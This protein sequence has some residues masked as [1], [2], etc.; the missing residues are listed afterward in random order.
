M[1]REAALPDQNPA[2][3]ND[4]LLFDAE[5]TPHR[6]LSPEGFL[7]LMA[8]VA[9]I[10][11][12][13]GLVFFLMG[14]WPVIGFLGAD[15]ALIY[16]AFKIS[17]RRGRLIERLQMT[18]S[19]LTVT[20]VWPGGKSRSWQFQTA[21]LQVLLEAPAGPGN[22]NDSQLVLRSHGRNLAIGSFL[23]KPE[24]ADLARALRSALAEA[25]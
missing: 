12:I 19:A 5:L 7:L 17:Y 15:V 1:T 11:F 8:G 2:G 23:T 3:E 20:R 22:R 21:W 18:D 6:S 4:D 14:A 9:T 25:R 16:I 13:A 24:R 10:S